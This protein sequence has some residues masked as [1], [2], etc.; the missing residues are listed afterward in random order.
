MLPHVHLLLGF[1]TPKFEKYDGHG[2]PTAHLKRYCNQLR[3]AGGKEELLMAYFG[4]SL[5]GIA[6]EWYMDQDISRCHIW[7]DLARDFIRQFQNNIDIAPDRNLLLNLK[8]KSSKSFREYAVKW[9]KQA[10]RV[11]PQMDETKMVSVF[12]Q[13]QEADY[14][15]NMMSMM[16]KPFAE[17]I[18]IGEMVENGLKI[19]RILSQSAIRAT[20]QAIQCGSGGVAN[21]KSRKKRQWQLQV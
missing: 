16:G 5:V 17:A 15:Q 18:K 2:D 1:K 21:R 6:S 9:L 3:G 11:K 13:A 7:D 20:S 10:T 8:K 14:Y 19:R 4:E 12:L